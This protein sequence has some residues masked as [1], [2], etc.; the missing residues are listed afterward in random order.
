MRIFKS[1][2]ATAF[3]A[4]AA[5]AIVQPSAAQDTH[6]WRMATSW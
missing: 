2:A 6:K 5:L 1:L 4:L 3:A